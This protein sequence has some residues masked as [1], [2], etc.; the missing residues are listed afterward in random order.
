[1]FI[2]TG[3]PFAISDY[4]EKNSRKTKEKEAKSLR[5]YQERFDRRHNIDN[6]VKL[7]DDEIKK[8]PYKWGF[9]LARIKKDIQKSREV[10]V[11]NVLGMLTLDS[12]LNNKVMM[13]SLSEVQDLFNRAL[14]QN[15][16]DWYLVFEQLDCPSR[17][18]LKRANKTIKFI[19]DYYSNRLDDSD[20]G[21]LNKEID[22]SQLKVLLSSYLNTKKS[23]IKGDIVYILKTIEEYSPLK[24]AFTRRSVIEAIDELYKIN[25]GLPKTNLPESNLLIPF[26][27]VAAWRVSDGYGQKLVDIVY[28]K[29]KWNFIPFGFAAAQRD[30]NGLDRKLVHIVYDN[31]DYRHAISFVNESILDHRIPMKS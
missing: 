24:I 1:M 5:E 31:L 17:I 7:A 23:E 9:G 29:I 18:K 26:G 15:T 10:S 28:D 8:N 27:I 6:F 30:S 19:R 25:G 20:K 4:I 11:K 2:L 3:Y 22:L 21:E 13:D 14:K 16:W 12:K